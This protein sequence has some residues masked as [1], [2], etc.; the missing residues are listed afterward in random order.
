MLRLTALP[1]LIACSLLTAGCEE[2]QPPERKPRKPAVEA[3]AKPQPASQSTS[4][5]GSASASGVSAAP[6]PP[7]VPDGFFLVTVADKDQGQPLEGAEIRSIP[8]RR[9]D[10]LGL[11]SKGVGDPASDAQDDIE[12]LAWFGEEARTNE[13]GEALLPYWEEEGRLA[14]T[15][16]HGVLFNQRNLK[17]DG[18]KF[19]DIKARNRGSVIVEMVDPEGRTLLNTAAVVQRIGRYG[20]EDVASA[21]TRE[22]GTAV[23]DFLERFKNKFEPEDQLAVAQLGLFTAQPVR[24]VSLA[25]L[26]SNVQLPA[27]PVGSL[28]LAFTG[29]NDLPVFGL[30]E[31]ELSI[32]D[33]PEG[34]SEP[35]IVQTDTGTIRF[36]HVGL[37]LQLVAKARRPGGDAVG[38]LELAGP[39]EAGQVV[40]ETYDANLT[41]L[42]LAGRLL[43]PDGTPL[44]REGVDYELVRKSFFDAGSTSDLLRTRPD[45][46]FQLFRPHASTQV[47]WDEVRLELSWQDLNG[48]PIYTATWSKTQVPVGLEDL[49]DVTLEQQPE[50]DE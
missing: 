50:D 11:T 9:F 46:S 35:V 41:G 43:W 27:Q 25:D 2:Y 42:T 45:G 14:L 36:D 44:V 7:F 21:P 4:G 13:K 6:T 16:R 24:P 3:E 33:A 20:Q 12:Y 47:T 30:L 8:L 49:G 39:T 10:N 5:A 32:K 23:L 37:G 29:A 15:V 1:T 38:E 18:K 17:K 28:E 48:G 19:V 26:P 31:V 22:D 40:S 34:A